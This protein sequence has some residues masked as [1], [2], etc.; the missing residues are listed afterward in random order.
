MNYELINGVLTD[1]PVWPTFK[2]WAKEEHAP[3]IVLQPLPGLGGVEKHEDIHIRSVIDYVTKRRYTDGQYRFFNEAPVPTNDEIFMTDDGLINII[4]NGE[5][6]GEVVTYANTRR[7]VKVI[8][9]FNPDRTK[10][11]VEEYAYDGN[12]YSTILYYEDK[13]SQIQ[14]LNNEGQVVL[15]QYVYDGVINLITIED[16][17]TGKILERYDDLTSFLAATVAKIVTVHDTVRI[18]YMGVEMNVLSKS[19]ARNILRL[20]ESPF[21]DSGAVRGFL[22]K[23]LQDQIKYIQEVEMSKA[24]YQALA[25][26]NIPLN[27]AS[28][29]DDSLSDPK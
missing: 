2:Q 15:R 17:L 12:Q 25:L 24:A 9:Y 26:Q 18:H 11:Y 22:L 19:P 28:V 29:V 14:F 27:K 10:D 7:A 16:P 4:D 3:F 6:I 13:L 20:V 1:S 5:T 23:I 21:D 8:T